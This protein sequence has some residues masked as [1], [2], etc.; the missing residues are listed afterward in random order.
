[1]PV[2]G[3]PDNRRASQGGVVD[4]PESIGALSLLPATVAIVL[5]FVTRNTVFSLALACFI[6]VL[7]AGQG[8]MGFPNLLKNALGTTAFSWIFLLELFIG[9]LIAF[10]QRTG[11]IRNFSA[12]VANRNMTRVRVQLVAWIMGMFVFFSDYFS[13]LFVGSTMREL[14]DRF[15]ISREKLAYIADS[16][17]APVSAV[18]ATSMRGPTGAP[19]PWCGC[20]R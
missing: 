2:A 10:F 8:L 6:G 7:V 3:L 14:S 9:M 12:W 18:E 13:P 17:S 11:A 19:M 16:T 4:Q 15:R 1:V 20:T 5:A